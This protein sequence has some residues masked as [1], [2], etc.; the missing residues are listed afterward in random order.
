MG[1]HYVKTGHLLPVLRGRVEDGDG[2]PVNLGAIGATS[3]LFHMRASGGTVRVI[4]D[5]QATIVNASQGDIAHAWVAGQTATVGFYESEFEVL[6]G[7][8]RSARL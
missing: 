8:W 4:D 5:A 2:L 6:V 3:V 1:M 7:T